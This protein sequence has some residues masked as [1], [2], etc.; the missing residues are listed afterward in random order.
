MPKI[1]VTLNKTNTAKLNKLLKWLKSNWSLYTE[2]FDEEFTEFIKK[3]IRSLKDCSEKSIVETY[4]DEGKTY[5]PTV[6]SED[7]TMLY[8]TLTKKVRH[9]LSKKY[10]NTQLYDNNIDI[11]FNEVKREYINH[12]MN[13]SENLEFCDE[14]RD[15]FIKNNLKLVIECAKRYQNLGM[16]FEDLIQCGNVGLVTSFE[17]YDTTRNNLQNAI[18]KAIEESEQDTFTYDESVELVKKCFTYNKNLDKTLAT[19][20]EEGFESKEVFVDWAKKNVKRAVFASIAFHWIRAYILLELSKYATIVRIPKTNKE[21]EN[22]SPTTSILRL[23]SINPHTDDCYHDNQIAGVANEEFLIED[24]YVDNLERQQ[25]FTEIINKALYKLDA[26]S[27]RVIKK[28]FGIGFPYQLT[29]S[30][31]AENEG[32]STS[33]VKYLIAGAMQDILN[34]ISESDKQLIRE[35]LE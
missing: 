34:N 13:E 20:P 17:H 24:S 7:Y 5:I 12:P 26:T 2:T 14:N 8:P 16:P 9:I 31:I 30:E 4:I 19:I 35:M 21:G 1:K 3:E 22:T 18:I 32:L 10:T 11:Y 25:C 27:A 33:K 28:R 29:V 15:I 23:D 6:T